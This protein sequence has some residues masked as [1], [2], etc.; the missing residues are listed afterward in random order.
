MVKRAAVALAVLATILAAAGCDSGGSKKSSSNSSGTTFSA[1]NPVN[2]NYWVYFSNPELGVMKQVVA[3]FEKTHPGIHV[4]TRGGIDDTKIL[5]SI[6]AGKSP[7]VAEASQS[8]YSGK[9]CSSGAWIDLNPNLQRDNIPASTF[10]PAPRYYTQY[11]GT[12]CAL[13]MLADAY[14]LYYNTAMFR[15]AGLTHPPRTMSELTQ[16]AKKLTVRNSDGSLKVVGLD[17]VNGWY[18]N[19]PAHWGPQ[20][21]AKWVDAKGNSIIAKSPGW[22]KFLQWQKELV[23][24]YGYKNL[25][26]WQAGAG[27]EFSPSHAFERGKVA[28]NLDGEWRVSLIKKDGSNV[29]YATA[30]LPVDDAQ[31]QLYGAGYTSGSILGIPKTAKNKDAAWE[32]V[33]YLATNTKAEALLS[34]GI[35]NVPTTTASAHSPLLKNDPRFAVFVRIF[36]NP[37]TMTTPVSIIGAQNQNLFSTFNTA[38]QTGHDTDLQGGLENVDEQ[39]NAA[40][41]QAGAGGVP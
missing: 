36:N 14:G 16:Y 7:D 13:P 26:K 31:P 41:K 19:A 3:E 28:M 5:A 32:L 23:D 15:K 4:T 38:Y 10:P 39:I 27:D 6:T 11:K 1:D 34:N 20:F 24:W 22:K 2:I 8:D 21:G 25:V 40:L 17:P 30:P 12:R 18:E 35:A 9:Y 37:H 29:Q 33:K